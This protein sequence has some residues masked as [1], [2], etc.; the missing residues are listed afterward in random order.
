MKYIFRAYK[1]YADF[2]GRASRKE[3]WFFYLFF[4]LC[5]IATSILDAMI[6][7]NTEIVDAAILNVL[8]VLGSVIPFC[9]ILTRRLH[10][11]NQSGLWVFIILLPFLGIILLMVLAL[12]GNE[13]ENRFGEDPLKTMSDY[14]I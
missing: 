10:D 6:L 14:I 3:F 2:K 1:K 4:M 7:I 9:A 13:G 5:T 11:I 8:F 12:K